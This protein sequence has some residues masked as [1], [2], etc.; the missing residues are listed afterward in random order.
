MFF[1][2]WVILLVKYGFLRLNDIVLENYDFVFDL[3]SD[4]VINIE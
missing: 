4:E 3:K 2:N 1:E